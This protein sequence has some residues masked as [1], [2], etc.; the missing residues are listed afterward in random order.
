M[1]LHTLLAIV[2]VAA[3]A[4]DARAQTRDQII[5][6][7]TRNRETVLAYVDAMPDSAMT[8]RPTPEVRSF[9]GQILHL[10]ET[11]LEV[12][13]RALRGEAAPPFLPDS[14][15]VPYQ[16]AA[17][18]DYA[19]RSY[20]YVLDALRAA[21][22]AVLARRMPMFDAGVESAARWMEMSREHAVWTLGQTVPYLRL[23]GVTPPVY[24]QPF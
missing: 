8:Y 10:T 19:D 14:L 6:D 2:L 23:N 11:N 22:P 7:W 16:K 21:T 9:A 15:T 12:A 5:A 17:L 13:A 18:R 4:A 24:K 3:P 20:A 1:K